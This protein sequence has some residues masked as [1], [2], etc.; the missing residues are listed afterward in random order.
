MLLFDGELQRFLQQRFRFNVATQLHLQFT[1]E[2]ARHHPVALFG[3]AKRQVRFRL[4]IPV[5]G[6]QRLGQAKPKTFVVRLSSD[7]F[8]KTFD[9]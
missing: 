4:G 8:L 9:S 1:E 5:L 3:H 2:D 7:Q 6:D